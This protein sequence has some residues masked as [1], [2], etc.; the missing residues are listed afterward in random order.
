MTFEKVPT[1]KYLGLDTNKMANS[2]EEIGQ[3]ITTGNKCYYLFHTSNTVQVKTTM[4]KN[5]NKTI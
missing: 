3:R 1:L 4:K 5:K 2:H